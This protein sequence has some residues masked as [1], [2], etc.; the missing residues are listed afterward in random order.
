MVGWWDGDG[1]FNDRIGGNHGQSFGTPSHELGIDGDALHFDGIDTTLSMLSPPELDVGQGNFSVV[2]WVRFDTLVAPANTSSTEIFDAGLV[3]KMAGTNSDGW[4]IHKQGEQNRIWFCFG[5]G[6]NG[7]GCEVG[8]ETLARSSTTVVPGQWYHVAA[9]KS[10]QLISLYI[11]GI[12]EDQA[13]ASEA[14]VSGDASLQLGA[15]NGNPGTKGPG[16]AF[17]NG[18]LDEVLLFDAPL[19]GRGIA[20]LREHGVCKE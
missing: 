14:F 1:T 10:D 11:D 8:D 4:R 12:F 13:V 2:F 5:A 15:W 3:S 16:D 19:N 7:N 9:V 6:K 20:R 17:F 18:D